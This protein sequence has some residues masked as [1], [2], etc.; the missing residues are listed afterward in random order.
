[1]KNCV[2]CLDNNM[3]S[4][5]PLFQNKSFYVLGM[6][7]PDRKHALMIIPKAHSETPF[8]MT[9]DEWADI[10]EPLAWAKDRLAAFK[11][12]GFTIGWNVGKVAGQTVAHV[13]MHVICRFADEPSTGAGINKLIKRV[14]AA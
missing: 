4:D 9:P 8:E 10:A 13:H 5:A 6:R 2:F 11:P 14:N 1:M 3:L 7:D 12:D